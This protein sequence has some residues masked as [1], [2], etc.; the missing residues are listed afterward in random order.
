MA[1]ELDIPQTQYGISF[2]GAYFRIVNVH[3]MRTANIHFRFNV[4]VDLAAYAT[5]PQSE[6]LREI[7]TRRYHCPLDEIEVQSGDN[8]LARCY[9]WV[10]AQPDMVGA[11]AV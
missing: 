4:I 3:I 1:I 8:F 10:M 6:P 5:N 9:E 11:I 2:A 7:E